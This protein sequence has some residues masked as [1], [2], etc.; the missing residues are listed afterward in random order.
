M[1]RMTRVLLTVTASLVVA[2][3]ALVNVAANVGRTLPA[4][5]G[6]NTNGAFRDGL[7]LG[8]LDAQQGRGSH[9]SVG[10]WNSAND[11]AAF[12]AGYT[13]GYAEN[14]EPGLEE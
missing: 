5:S 14:P 3:Y 9:L 11:R 8:K 7:Y 6:L 2:S 13:T 4:S 10:R 1:K 12:I